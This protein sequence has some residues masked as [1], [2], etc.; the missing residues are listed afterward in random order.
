[1][2]YHKPRFM[3]NG[4]SLLHFRHQVS[5]RALG[6]GVLFY[7]DLERPQGRRNLLTF[8]LIQSLRTCSSNVSILSQKLRAQA[9]PS[10][11][12]VPDM[13]LALIFCLCSLL[14]R[15]VR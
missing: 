4:P 5:S 13:A 14:S 12:N 6:A 8:S 15:W 1:M 10:K 7:L 9:R 2:R 3:T 11:R